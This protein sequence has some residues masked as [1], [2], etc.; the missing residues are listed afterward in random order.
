[1]KTYSSILVVGVTKLGCS[2][3][4]STFSRKR[5]KRNLA[6]NEMPVLFFLSSWISGTLATA[7]R[8]NRQTYSRYADL[9]P[10]TLPPLL[11]TFQSN[12]FLMNP[13][14]DLSRIPSRL[15]HE[16]AKKARD[17]ISDLQIHFQLKPKEFVRFHRTCKNVHEVCH[18][19]KNLIDLK[20]NNLFCETV[21]NLR[22]VWKRYRTDK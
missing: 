13:E 3:N 9:F 16:V 5:T 20:V 19:H 10:A 14:L 18:Q 2:Q 17:L 11:L 7:D 1:M 12:R 22:N 15:V 4:T 21:G 8:Q 6:S